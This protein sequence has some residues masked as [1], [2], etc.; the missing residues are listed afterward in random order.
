[1]TKQ[2]GLGDGH[3]SLNDWVR[4]AI[5][6]HEAPYFDVPRSFLPSFDWVT[7][8]NGDMMVDYIAKLETIDDDWPE[9]QKLTGITNELP[10]INKTKT[11]KDPTH[12]LDNES[13]KILQDVF[14]RDFETFGYTA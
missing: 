6:D 7:D 11:P 10:K 5:R 14:A 13:R 2:T 8:E 3:I 12:G 4:A 9:I 1:M